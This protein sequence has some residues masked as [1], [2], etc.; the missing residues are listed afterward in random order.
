LRH[1]VER[2]SQDRAEVVDV[3]EAECRLWLA[4]AREGLREMAGAE[5]VSVREFACTFLGAIVGASGSLFL[6]IGDGAI[7]VSGEDQPDEYDPVIWP[8]SGEYANTTFFVYSDDAEDHLHVSAGAPVAEVAVFTDGLQRL[9]L[10]LATRSAHNPFFRAFF[11]RLRQQPPG[12]S[13]PMSAGLSTFLN[14]KQVVERTDD[15]KT[16]VLATRVS[17]DDEV[18]G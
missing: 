3:T 15:D 11:S 18:A 6:Q 2:L 4:E 14:S 7:V 9:A 5:A 16:L 13:E 1:F 12:L 17:P 8:E 10:H